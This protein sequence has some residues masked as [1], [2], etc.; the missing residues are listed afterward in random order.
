[1]NK[2]EFVKA[3]R[4]LLLIG[5]AGLVGL[6][7]ARILRTSFPELPLAI[8]G[9]D[10]ERAREAAGELENASAVAVDLSRPDLGL[11][12]G[13]TF[14]GIALFLHDRTLNGLRFAQAREIPYLSLSSGAFELGAEFTLGACCRINAPVLMASSWMAGAGALPALSLARSL[15]RVDSIWIGAVS[16]PDDQR[17]PATREDSARVQSA[18]YSLV[19][20]DGKLEWLSPEQAGG[21]VRRIDGEVLP[22]RAFGAPDVPSLFATTTAQNIRLDVARRES[23]S[24]AAGKGI[25]H[26]IIV[27]VAGQS[28]DGTNRTLQLAIVQPNGL[29]PLLAF[30]ASMGIER[31]LGLAG[32]RPSAGV[33]V[34]ETLIDPGEY[35]RRLPS[36]GAEVRELSREPH[37]LRG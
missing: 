20:Q 1:M 14:S 15:E 22:S 24:R 11:A 18:C 5:G 2:A 23:S 16:D 9:R 37:F 34:C 25:S 29:A 30:G 19:V 31:L 4:P 33:Y 17:G 6:H 10:L 32:E 13:Q 36:N 7:T 3:S 28:A 12:P 21:S 27:E 26:E 35:I 8:A